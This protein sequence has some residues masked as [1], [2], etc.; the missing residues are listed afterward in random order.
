MSLEN[1][2]SNGFDFHNRS[3][4]DAHGTCA[5]RNTALQTLSFFIRYR[6]CT[7]NTPKIWRLA[8]LQG[9]AVERRHRAINLTILAFHQRYPETNL[10]RL[11]HQLARLY[12]V[13]KLT[14]MAFQ[15]RLI[16]GTMGPR[17]QKSINCSRANPDGGTVA[18]D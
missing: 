1:S 16:P 12:P 7:I 13:M 18:A 14:I 9:Y 2:R 10:D 15:R 17:S 6:W 11:G 5:T 4:L 3:P 8:A